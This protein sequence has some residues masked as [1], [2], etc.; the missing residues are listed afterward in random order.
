MLSI[1]HPIND[2]ITT[3]ERSRH[4][5]GSPKAAE[6]RYC[7]RGR[8]TPQ[9]GF[10]PESQEIV[11]GPGSTAAAAGGRTA[12]AAGSTAVAGGSTAVAAGSMAVAAVAAGSIAA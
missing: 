10:P 5:R 8:I 1:M 3:Q 11:V 7:R 9:K 6:G 4:G 2:T 12:A